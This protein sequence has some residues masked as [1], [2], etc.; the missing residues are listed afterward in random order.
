MAKPVPVPRPF[1]KDYKR[2]MDKVSVLPGGCWE[3]T[4]GRFT[5]GYGVFWL[6][7]KQRRAH[8]VL[9]VWTYGELGDGDDLD[10]LCRNRWCVNPEHLEVVTRREN[11]LRGIGPT[12]ENAKK[13]ISSS[14][15]PLDYED[16]R[17]WRGSKKDRA[18]ASKRYYERNRDAVNAK[19][20]AARIRVVYDERPCGHCGRPYQPVRS[21]SR[22]CSE[23]DCVNSRQR[24]NRL[25]RIARNRG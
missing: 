13:K 15:H 5:H 20:R 25:H 1:A 23:R 19:K 9:Y 24:E 17:G 18:A 2:F 6:D 10:H 7:G 4:G 3:W 12:A 11:V 22:Y 8:R 14:G 16:D 21:T